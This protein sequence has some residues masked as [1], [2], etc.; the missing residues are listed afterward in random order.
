MHNVLMAELDGD[1]ERISFDVQHV[2]RVISRNK[3]NMV[4]SDDKA[5]PYLEADGCVYPVSK[6][7]SHDKIRPYFVLHRSGTAFNV[8]GYKMLFNVKALPN[9]LVSGEDATGR[10]YL[11]RL[12]EA[13]RA[14]GS[15]KEEI[16]FDEINERLRQTNESLDELK[17][18]KDVFSKMKKGEFFEALTL[19]FSGKIKEIAQELVDFRKDIQ[20][21]IQPDIVEL[22]AR[23]IPE[24]SN[25]LEGINQTL[26]SSTMKIMDINDEQMEIA[27]S[28]L[29]NLE[30]FVSGNGKGVTGKT[31]EVM[32]QEMKSLKRISDLS[33]SMMEPLSF[34]D[35]VGQRIQRIIKLVKSM[36][37]RIE[38]LIITFGIKIQRH[39]EDPERS[40][41]DLRQDVE[42]YR[43]ELKGPQ[44]DGEG[45]EQA[46]IDELLATL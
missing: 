13:D 12:Y 43:S 2:N 36:E 37:V 24:A 45:L 11:C 20:K 15:K 14:D 3:V 46:D 5:G 30:S 18:L 38:D 4:N 6:G 33:L 42:N 25:Q 35:L 7:T 23:D 9:N 29:V 10:E 31:R 41:E 26:E 28:Q 44:K 40:F 32:E 16:S 27:K 21:K 34:Q 19:E 17:E 39:R 8:N 1:L 22:A